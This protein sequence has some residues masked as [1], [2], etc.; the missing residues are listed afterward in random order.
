M[1]DANKNPAIKNCSLHHVTIQA[2][3]LAASLRFYQNVLG[4]EIV[5]E[6]G[7][8]GRKIIMLDVGDGSHVELF[9]PTADT[10]KVGNPAAN[11][12]IIHLAL[13]TSDA[14]AA[15]ER[16]RQ[17]G[18]EITIEPKAIT[19]GSAEATITFC[20]GPNGEAIEFLQMH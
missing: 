7:S 19:V 1:P 14:K 5:A 4:M 6:F 18:Y 13:A 12:P 9:E 8:P 20:K 16:V 3:D 11:D 10:P 2:R 15:A 17:A